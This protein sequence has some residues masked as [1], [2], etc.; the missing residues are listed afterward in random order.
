MNFETLDCG[1][2]HLSAILCWVQ[3]NRLSSTKT[4]AASQDDSSERASACLA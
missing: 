1:T 4:S 2:P 3:P